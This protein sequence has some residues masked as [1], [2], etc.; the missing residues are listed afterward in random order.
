MLKFLETKELGALFVNVTFRLNNYPDKPV[1][2]WLGYKQVQV[3]ADQILQG[4]ILATDPADQTVIF[5]YLLSR[6]GNSVAMWRRKL[7]VP[8]EVRQK[9]LQALK[10]VKAGLRLDK[11]LIY[12]DEYVIREL[13]YIYS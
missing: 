10:K 8:K 4:S 12:D 3:S 9:H 1:F 13:L 5:V 11:E 7:Q 2:D 6:T